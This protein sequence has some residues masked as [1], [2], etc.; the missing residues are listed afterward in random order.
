MFRLHIVRVIVLAFVCACA[1]RSS[2]TDKRVSS[3]ESG[4]GFTL[5]NLHPDN[6]RGRLFAVNFQQ[7]GLIPVCSEVEYLGID[8]DSFKFRVVSTG[9]KYEYFNHKAA[10]E[11]FSDHLNR[12]FGAV[13]PREEI[14]SLS[15]LDR[16]G[17]RDGH[18]I[19]GM[20]RRGV[21]LAMGHPPR[22]VNPD[23]NAPTLM[24]WRNRFNRVEIQFGGPDD[25]VTGMRD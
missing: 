7:A 9:R 13:C 24:Y 4:N 19:K 12:F 10:A 16:E 3:F 23:P 25:R 20:T 21:I 18:A 14:A 5:V 8:D 1:A 2:H 22:H 15:D 17:I 11:P 6:E